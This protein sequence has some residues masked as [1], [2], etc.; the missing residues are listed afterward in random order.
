MNIN[1]YNLYYTVIKIR[2]E[3]EVE[4]DKNPFDISDF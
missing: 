4:D 2:D 1:C 3:K